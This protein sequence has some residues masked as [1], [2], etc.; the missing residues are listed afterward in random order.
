MTGPSDGPVRHG[1]A[2]VLDAEPCGRWD[3]GMT[4]PPQD[5]WSPGAPPPAYGQ[6]PPPGWQQPPAYGAPAGT[7]QPY[8]GEDPGLREPVWAV[9]AHVSLY[10]FPLLGPLV[11]YLV[12]KDTSPFTRHHAAEALNLSITLFIV[13]VVS[14]PLLFVLVGFPLLLA[15]ALW[16]LVAPILGAVAAGNRRG[17]RYPVTLHLVS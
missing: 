2:S 3:G 14:I 4:Q 7:P 6:G 9:L 11:I 16:G 12:Y 8:G 13:V 5:P 17:Y 15:A 1:V 10:V